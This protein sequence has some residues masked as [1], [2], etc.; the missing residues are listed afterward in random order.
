MKKK[1]EN[2]D[3][4]ELVEALIICGYI[5]DLYDADSSKETL[6][7]KLCEVIEVIWARRMGFEAKAITQKSGYE[8]VEII[9]NDK[10][11]VSDTKSFRLSRSQAAPNVKDFVKP[12]DYRTWLSRKDEGKRL[13]G[14][15]VYPQLHE[16]A[17][18]SNAHKY[19][20]D[21]LNPIVMLPFHYLAYLLKAKNDIGY[22]TDK[23]IELWD[24]SSIFEQ[25]FENRIGYWKIINNK[26][27]SITGDSLDN[28]KEFLCNSEKKMYN[29]VLE[30]QRLIKQA[31]LQ[32][33]D[34]V[35]QELSSIDEKQLREEFVKY[36]LIKETEGLNVLVERISKFRIKGEGTN[37]IQFI[38]QE[39]E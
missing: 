2:T 32:K 19:C 29:F 33:E 37:Y 7:T 15:V 34:E 22:E 1:L 39:F 36:K 4:N 25:G 20:S 38:E 26:I 30:Q 14:L 31:I 17:K 24:F 35:E 8:D 12:E 23:L 16:W 10:I 9:I 13:G 3:D 5:P 11:I 28:L 18:L 27:I 6:F 21:K